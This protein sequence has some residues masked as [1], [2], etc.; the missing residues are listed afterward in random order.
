MAF[1][2]IGAARFAVKGIK[3]GI[4][5]HKD[6]QDPT[7][8]EREQAVQMDRWGNPKKPGP[9]YGWVMKAE[10]QRK[11]KAGAESGIVTGGESVCPSINKD[12]RLWLIDAETSCGLWSIRRTR[13]ELD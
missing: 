1:L 12:D 9:V 11:G 4:Q 3:D 6:A 10:Q 2:V 5:A 13:E 7:F 8:A